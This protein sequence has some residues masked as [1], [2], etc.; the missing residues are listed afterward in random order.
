MADV[1]ASTQASQYI[2]VA[3]LR[4]RGSER[5]D[6]SSSIIICSVRKEH[7][8]VMLLKI[9]LRL[10]PSMVNHSHGPEQTELS[11][12]VKYILSISNPRV[13]PAGP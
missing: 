10:L 12:K 11:P 1:W 5:F 4:S 3:T 7:S 6:K 13:V 8:D 2:R 9:E